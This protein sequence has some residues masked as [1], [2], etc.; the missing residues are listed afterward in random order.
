MVNPRGRSEVAEHEEST[1]RG[2]TAARRALFDQIKSPLR[3]PTDS[4]AVPER[5][6]REP[7]VCTPAYFGGLLAR[8]WGEGITTVRL[9]LAE[10]RQQ[11]YTGS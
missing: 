6:T 1:R 8:R 5:N 2:R 4:I 9:L 3:R 7:K 10:I 11:G